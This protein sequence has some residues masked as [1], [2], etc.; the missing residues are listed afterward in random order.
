M[1]EEVEI[2]AMTE[3][4]ETAAVT[5]MEIEMHPCDGTHHLEHSL[6]LEIEL[7]LSWGTCEYKND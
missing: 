4:A 3:E 1:A 6:D 2:A 5:E 7:D